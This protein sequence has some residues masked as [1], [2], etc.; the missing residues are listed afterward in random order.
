[1]NESIPIGF[2]IRFRSALP[3]RQAFERTTELRQKN[4]PAAVQPPCG[5]RILLLESAF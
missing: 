2:R 1:M 4:A 3:I 5:A